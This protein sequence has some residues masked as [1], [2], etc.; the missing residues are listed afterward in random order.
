[1][2]AFDVRVT[3]ELWNDRSIDSGS[4]AVVGSLHA[5][6]HSRVAAGAS[7]L[8]KHT[9]LRSSDSRQ[10][11]ARC[12]LS[13]G[14]LLGIGSAVT[15]IAKSLGIN[16]RGRQI[17]QFD[18]YVEFARLREFILRLER[19]DGSVVCVLRPIEAGLRMSD[20]VRLSYEVR[21]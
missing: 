18:H 17:D 16:S 1:M 9:L 13:G 2:D 6:E 11:R 20:F 4:D 3:S 19:A 14:T 21:Q 10:L 7:E 5:V 15:A 8:S 12:A